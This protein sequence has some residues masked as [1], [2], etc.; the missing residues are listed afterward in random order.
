M[1]SSGSVHESGQRVVL[2]NALPITAAVAAVTT[3]PI[4]VLS[5]ALYLGAH[6]IFTFGSGG[7]NAKFWLQT[8]FDG[9]T[10]WIDI[11]NMAFLVATLQKV[12]SVSAHLIAG[13][14]G[15]VVAPTDGTL[16]DDT[17]RQG[18]LGTQLRVKYTTTGTYAGGTTISINAVLKG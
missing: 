1:A 10:S 18:L 2:L 4:K 15:T 3:T 6:G 14:A 16:A 7:T 5:G 17:T 9:G 13:V 11:L 8:S 12:G